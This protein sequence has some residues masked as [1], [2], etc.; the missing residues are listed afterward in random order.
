MAVLAAILPVVSRSSCLALDLYQFAASSP[1][2]AKDLVKAA[3]A[4]NNFASILKQVG[5]IIK[6]DDRLPSFEALDVLEDAT[7][8][9][10]TVLKEIE[11]AT[12]LRRN[13][14]TEETDEARSSKGHPRSGSLNVTRLAC[15]AAHLECLRLTLAV[16]LQTLYTAQSIMW[17]KL[18]PTVSPK[19][20]AKAVAN[21][22]IQLQTLII[23]QQM[24]ILSA[25]VL[26]NQVPRQDAR[27]L[28]ESDSSQSLV[29]TG[30][31]N[32]SP[33]SNH[34]YQYQDKYLGSLDTSGST[35]EG[36][37]PTVC[38]IAGPR[39]EL[40]LERWTSLPDF[41]Q[42]L[43]DAERKA[44]TQKHEN[45]QATVESD[46]EEEERQRYGPNG[47][48]LA[49][50]PPQRSGSVQPLFMDT[51]TLP[52]PVPGSK[53]GPSAP[54]SPAASPRASRTT[55][56]IPVSPRTSIGSLPVEAA[57]AV[58]A[59]EEDDDL[60]L[61]IPWTLR[62][63]KYEWRFI[64]GKVVGS[65]TDLPFSAAYAERRSWT[66]VLASWACKEAIQEAGYKFT[67]VQKERKDGRRTKFDTCFCIE[68][69][70][71]FDQVKRLVER[72]VELYRKNVSPT[73]PPQPALPRVRRTSFDRPP[74]GPPPSY[75][76][77]MAAQDRDRTPTASRP[78]MPL[79]RSSSTVAYRPP[80]P[81][82]D[83]SM[84]MPG[85]GMVPPPPYPPSINSQA[86]TRPVAMP[87]P[88]PMPMTNGQYSSLPSQ[89]LYP[90]QIP[91]PPPN[92]QQY[93]YPPP[94]PGAPYS[95][96]Q[97]PSPTQLYANP[98]GP[99]S[100]MRQSHFVPRSTDRY[101]D[102]SMTSDS[103]SGERR[104]RRSKSRKR[105]EKEVEGKKKKYGKSA[106]VG[107]LMGIGGLTALLDGLGGL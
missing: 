61:E 88:G 21:E 6:E 3:N 20:A 44:R 1:G 91:P 100:P 25:T 43:R 60:D 38:S 56:E 69:P 74:P 102:D 37:L 39:T 15:F 4:I 31:E 11:N 12:E 45:Q 90:P 33:N 80:P 75:L 93:P 9:S 18:R 63:Q 26:H 89:S 101:D 64:D 79:E 94:P 92:A 66:E 8:Q 95:N 78:Q 98:S 57:A 41:D 85:P 58:E 99:Q 14:Q 76:A 22:K 55:L 27:F 65:N 106:A 83:R 34:L 73:P 54:M 97:L 81:P 42:R 40:L 77:K 62:T 29:I 105:Y 52:I 36:W 17:S 53:F 2:E 84:S 32:T 67:Q 103:G 46:S 7:V 23:E 59:K 104:R 68:Q 35:E 19:Q 107:T 24:S 49:S 86:P 47:A 30:R 51:T 5:T 70:L 71:K 72:T 82:L 50:P 28:M 48:G 87:T 13:E 10:Q 16:L 96:Y